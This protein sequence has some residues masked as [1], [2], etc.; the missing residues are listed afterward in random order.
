MTASPMDI[1]EIAA[2]AVDFHNRLETAKREIGARDFDW[3][4]YSSLYIW[5]S[6]AN[7]L[8]GNHRQLLELARDEPVLDA[9]CGDG[10]LAFFLESLGCRVH[11]IDWP[12]TNYN[13]MR[14]V[15]ALK[16]ALGSNIEITEVDLDR[17]FTLPDIRYSLVL[18]F[19]V[20][21]HLKNPFYILETLSYYA[22]WCLLTTRI[23]GFT[24]NYQ[25]SLKE[26]PVA[27][28]LDP[29][30]TNQDWTNYWIF[31]E[32]GLK[33]L[34]D[35][36]NWDLCEF[37]TVGNERSDPSSQEGDQ[38]ALCL[39]KRRLVDCVGKGE[40][41]HGW[42]QITEDGWRWTERRFSV[43]FSKAPAGRN[44]HLVAEF[45]IP[46]IVLDQLGALRLNVNVNGVSLPAQTYDAP[47][48]Q[49]YQA[50][51]PGG[52]LSGGRAVVEFELDKGIPPGKTDLRELGLIVTAVELT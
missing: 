41:I 16:A 46:E 43:A 51:V 29:G 4:P 40:L 8:S 36:T 3:Y 45:V 49:S 26:I 11:A 6:F 48:T 50:T 7:V 34:F 24:P 14:G 35:R 20:L 28:L 12:K 17:Q 39:A 5:Q 10:D 21:Y 15:R 30:E 47:G 25:T 37:A 2:R 23:A 9:G 18:L 27:Y 19:G 31:S 52:A 38:R 42:H 13:Q 22:R 33:R 44:G 1:A 32:A